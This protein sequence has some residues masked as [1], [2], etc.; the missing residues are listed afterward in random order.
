MSDL[1][2][3]GQSILRGERTLAHIPLPPLST[4]ST[5]EM[6]VNVVRGKQ[7]G[8]RLLVCAALHGDEINGVE[9]IRRLLAHPSMA[10]IR[11]DLIAV[12]I[13]N[14]YGF[15]HQS[16][17]LP[18]RRDLNRC[19][20]GSERG[21]MAGRL[22]SIFFNDVV[23]QC[24]HGIDLHTAAIHRDNLPQIRACL[25]DSETMEM[26]KAFPVPILL[27]ASLR[28][29][30]IREA[31]AKAGI[32]WLVYEAG[33]A[34]RFDEVAIRVGVRG[35]LQVMRQI[36]ML[37][38]KVKKKP[39]IPK[40]A[41]RSYW[42]RAPQSGLYRT[43]SPMGKDLEQGETLGMIGE[44]YG[45]KEAAVIAPT[46]GIVIGRTNLPLVHEGDA[47]CHIARFKQLGS[48][49]DTMEAFQQAFDIE[50]NVGDEVTDDLPIV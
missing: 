32:P 44:P 42:V 11:G 47:L 46:S 4:Q 12:P 23:K 28:Q 15:I 16:R 7:N 20:P 45:T 8:P 31:A 14:I 43:F 13:V 36:G 19:F 29:G 37:P 6:A 17:Y 48:V 24:T 38:N 2:I 9:I 25:S 40:I 50:Q 3:G 10:R 22:A 18:D 30:T 41:S 21:T 27:D 39:Y 34:L 33:E 49:V 26:A 1:V 35:I 5:L